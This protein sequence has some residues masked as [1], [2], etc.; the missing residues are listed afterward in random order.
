MELVLMLCGV[1][2]VWTVL[3]GRSEVLG[4]VAATCWAGLLVLTNLEKSGWEWGYDYNTFFEGARMLFDHGHSPYAAPGV[5]AFPF[6]TFPLIRLLSLGGRMSPEETRWS[7]LALEAVLLAV[8]SALLLRTVPGAT[9]SNWGRTAVWIGLAIH[10]KI[11]EGIV[12][13]NSSA[14]A[15]GLLMLALWSWRCGRGRPSRHLAAIMFNLAW[16]VKPHLIMAAAFF[17]ACWLFR[18]RP[19]ESEDRANAIG[20]LFF[21][22]SATLLALSLFLLPYDPW[23]L[24]LDFFRTAH[25]WHTKIAEAYTTNYALSAILAKAIRRLWGLPFSQTLP[26]MTLGVGLPLLLWN[27]VT[28]L[29]ARRNSIMAFLPWLFSSLLWTSLVWNHYLSLLLGGMLLMFGLLACPSRIQPASGLFFSSGIALTMVNSSFLFT[30]GILFL[31]LASHALLASRLERCQTEE[32][33][34]SRFSTS[35]NCEKSRKSG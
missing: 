23:S 4:G 7:F 32:Q 29:S 16:M 20:R 25:E 15:G 35:F 19:A 3:L 8:A 17:P 9:G 28:L 12:L 5:T 24:Y 34:M 18:R 2:A 33:P 27:C 14:L 13:G 10:P 30:L 21:P 1:A 22:W 11:V 6:P 26:L 31:Y